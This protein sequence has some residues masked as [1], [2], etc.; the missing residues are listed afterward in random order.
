MVSTSAAAS[1]NKTVLILEKLPQIA[2]KLKATGGG[3]CNLSNTLSDE[4]FM[5]RF[6]R[7]GKF[8]QDALKAFNHKDL[9]ETLWLSFFKEPIDKI[10][11]FTDSI[12]SELR[13]RFFSSSQ[14]L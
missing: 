7:D 14:A 11:I 3:R 8:M 9:I 5:S 12:Y 10:P 1:Q 2:S 6:G 4:E 13:N